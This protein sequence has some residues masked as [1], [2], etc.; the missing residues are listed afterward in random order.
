MDWRLCLGFREWGLGFRD[1][2][3]GFVGLG[4]GHVGERGL[5]FRARDGLG[6]RD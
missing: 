3:L 4:I 5:R 6:V 2:Y 1:W